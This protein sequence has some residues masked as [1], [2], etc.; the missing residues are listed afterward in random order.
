MA[1]GVTVPAAKPGNLNST[2]CM[3]GERTDSHELFSDLHMSAPT[4]LCSGHTDTQTY[5]LSKQI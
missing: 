4:R 5:T 2:H 1:Q 3:V